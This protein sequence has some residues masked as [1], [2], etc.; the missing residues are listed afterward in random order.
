MTRAD[1]DEMVEAQLPEFHK[2]AAR[3]CP[4]GRHAA[5]RVFRSADR[6]VFA[7]GSERQASKKNPHA[8]ARRYT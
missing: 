4:N 7:M 8:G 2:N 3:R 1:L 6:T 5:H